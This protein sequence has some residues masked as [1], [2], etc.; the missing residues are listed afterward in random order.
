MGCWQP[1]MGL[2]PVLLRT[3]ATAIQLWHVQSTPV[4]HAPAA[5]TA[6]ATEATTDDPDTAAAERGDGVT[7]DSVMRYEWS[8]GARIIAVTMHTTGR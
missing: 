4:L 5:T 6:S 7:E 1:S 3:T 8:M 2:L